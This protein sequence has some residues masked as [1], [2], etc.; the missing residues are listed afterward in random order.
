MQ[1]AELKEILQCLPRYKTRFYYFKDRYALLLLNLA[2]S[3]ETS[4]KELKTTRFGRLL[5]KE[6]VKATLAQCRGRAL[7]G[8]DFEA[9]WPTRYECYYLTLGAWGSRSGLWNQTSRRGYNLVLQLNFSSEHDEPY[10]RLVDPEDDRP[11]EFSGH[12]VARG[13]MHTLAWSRMDIDLA[14]GE[15]LIEEIQ[16]DWVREALWARRMAVRQRGPNYY[17]GS[18]RQ[19]E[20]VVRYVDSVLRKHQAIWDEAM[21]SATIWFLRKEL[22]IS[23]IYYHS[24]A[25]GAALKKISGSL[26]P[27]SLYTKLPRKF[28][29]TETRES[30]GFLF[31]KSRS[32][33]I[34]KQLDQARFQRIVL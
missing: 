32:A 19:N 23:S 1:R 28:C 11:F 13:P 21:L 7:S 33:S 10:R 17:W 29:F 15:A 27:R 5:E 6:V 24:H 14:K 34:R 31:Q 18:K 20:W 9:Y 16:N 3:G 12:P 30:P 25:T 4:K 8:E 2:V 26:P 22:G